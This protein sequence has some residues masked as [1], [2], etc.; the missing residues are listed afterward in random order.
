MNRPPQ[1]RVKRCEICRTRLDK[2]T[3]VVRAGGLTEGRTRPLIYLCPECGDEARQ[4]AMGP[5]KVEP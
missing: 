2:D 3:F 5:R 4:L 1:K